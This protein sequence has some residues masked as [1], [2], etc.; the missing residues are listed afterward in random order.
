MVQP[1]PSLSRTNQLT[2]PTTSRFFSRTTLRA[3]ND[4]ISHLI[5]V[6]TVYPL[7]IAP[8]VSIIRKLPAWPQRPRS[9]LTQFLTLLHTELHS[10]ES[11][12]TLPHQT[13]VRH[14]KNIIP[15]SSTS[16]RSPHPSSK[17]PSHHSQSSQTLNYSTPPIHNDYRY[18]LVTRLLSCL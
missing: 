14:K 11:H 15:S 17:S 9:R 8:S 5:V 3:G 1:P 2:R 7:H 10:T 13:L 18:G 16:T 12:N 4:T 6:N